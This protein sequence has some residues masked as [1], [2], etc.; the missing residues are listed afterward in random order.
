MPKSK[1]K[2]S[3]YQPP[4]KKKPK[5][6]PTWFGVT[7][8]VVLLFGVAVIVLNYLGIEQILPGAPRNLYLWGGLGAIALGFGLATQWR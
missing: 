5:P 8:L 2:R 6:S 3:R 4:P 7:I 1:S